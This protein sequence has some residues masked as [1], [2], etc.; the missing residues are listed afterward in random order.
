M[1]VGLKIILS[2]LLVILFVSATILYTKNEN[3]NQDNNSPDNYFTSCNFDSDCI[4]VPAGMCSCANGGKAVAINKS[5]EAE[6]SEKVRKNQ[7]GGGGCI[8]KPSNDATCR[9]YPRC[10]QNHCN[11]FL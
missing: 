9:A 11:F 7:S 2:S 3:K 8:A 1:N 6:W 10:V 4:S 5:K